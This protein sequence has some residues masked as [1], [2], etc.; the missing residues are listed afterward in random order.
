MEQF[1]GAGPHTTPPNGLA[2]G[3]SLSLVG[4]ATFLVGRVRRGPTS[5]DPN[6][7]AMSQSGMVPY[8]GQVEGFIEGPQAVTLMGLPCSKVEW[9]PM[10]HI[11]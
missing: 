10:G 8:G 4:F 1:V 7:L 3:M 11:P 9:F 5:S 2:Y 6:G